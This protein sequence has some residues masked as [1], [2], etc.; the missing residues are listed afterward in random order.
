MASGT[1]ILAGYPASFSLS[2][3]FVAPQQFH[4]SLTINHSCNVTVLQGS[5]GDK[6]AQGEAVS[7]L[8]HDVMCDHLLS[9]IKYK[10]SHLTHN[11]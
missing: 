9:F 6:G 8:K 11:G 2:L 5:K 10:S 4:T 1:A 7:I 3:L